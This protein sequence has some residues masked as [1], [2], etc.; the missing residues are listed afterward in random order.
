MS[1]LSVIDQETVAERASNALRRYVGPRQTHSYAKAA[2]AVGVEE[3]SMKAWVLGEQAP[4]LYRWLRLVAFLGP[5]FADDVL[6]M[7]GIRC[8][9]VDQDGGD[10]MQLLASL[11]TAVDTIAQALADDGRIDHRERLDI[12]EAIRRLTEVTTP[13]LSQHDA[14]RQV[15]SIRDRISQVAHDAMG[16]RERGR[17]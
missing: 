6:A 12:A 14:Q 4:P 16:E 1:E 15:V 9:R 17:T 8:K 11:S 13:W 3:R 7:A 5:G 2:E 10:D